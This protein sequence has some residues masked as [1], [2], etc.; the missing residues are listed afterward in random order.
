MLREAYEL[1]SDTSPGRRMTQQRANILN[2][3][4]SG[5]SGRSVG[6]RP[7]KN[8]STLRIYFSRTKQLLAYFFRVVWSDSGHFTRERPDQELP[9]D[10]IQPTDAQMQAMGEAVEA[11][12]QGE[13]AE[14]ALK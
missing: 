14:L 12:R 3:F 7:F 6:F 11:A 10:V 2:E 13:G 5:A 9:R 8:E 4:Y 1:C